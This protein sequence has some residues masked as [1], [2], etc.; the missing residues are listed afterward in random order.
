M[1]VLWLKAIKVD[2][3]LLLQAYHK[4]ARGCSARG[5]H[6]GTQAEQQPL[7]QRLKRKCPWLFKFLLLLP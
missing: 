4:S 1:S 2:F 7:G 6:S 5:S 3:L